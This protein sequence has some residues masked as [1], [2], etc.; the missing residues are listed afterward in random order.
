MSYQEKINSYEHPDDQIL[1]EMENSGAR[2]IREMINWNY[3]NPNF[4]E[5][6][7]EDL[8][9]DEELFLFHKIFSFLK[10]PG[11][12]IP[13]SLEIAYRKSIFSGRIKNSGHI[14]SGKTKQWEHHFTKR[15]KQRFVELFGDALIYLGY[16]NSNQWAK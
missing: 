3:N 15:N 11:S 13:R 16:E 12:H 6:K 9:T 2:G 14:R 5:V 7:Y 8:I 10:I 1:F 4:L